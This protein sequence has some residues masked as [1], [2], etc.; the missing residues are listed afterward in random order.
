MEEMKK[1]HGGVRAG[2]GRPAINPDRRKVTITFSMSPEL[3]SKLQAEAARRGMSSSELMA[4]IL[5]RA[6]K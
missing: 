3:K 2:A 5:G 4:E 6:L 1:N